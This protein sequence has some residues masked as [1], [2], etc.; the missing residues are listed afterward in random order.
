MKIG[1][2]YIKVSRFIQFWL[3][4]KIKGIYVFGPEPKKPGFGCTLID[5][6]YHNKDRKNAGS[7][8]ISETAPS[9]IIFSHSGMFLCMQ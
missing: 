9:I 8:F 2:P 1:G 3:W 5:K 6:I 4:S 7:K